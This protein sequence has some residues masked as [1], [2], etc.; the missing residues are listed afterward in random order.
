[1]L[2][3]VFRCSRSLLA[4]A[5]VFSFGYV[6]QSGAAQTAPLSPA[7]KALF[8][9]PHLSNVTHPETL[10]YTYQRTGAETL[11]D[12]I[13]VHVKEIN[14][15]GTKDL[16]FDYLTGARHVFF[17]PID[18]FR[19]NPLLMLVLERDVTMMK[20][21]LGM[22]DA[23]FRN[24]IRQAFLDGAT[25][26]DTTVPFDGAATPARTVTITPFAHEQRLERIPSLQAKTYTFTLANAVPGMIANIRI[27][28]PSDPAL[29]APEFS[30]QITFA[31]VEP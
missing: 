26:A 24:R 9:T 1:M 23:Y 16:K 15:D 2:A 18:H 31:G 27:D 25:V 11:S 4:C 3:S 29:H 7:Q 13:A 28:T 21:A 14:S 5:V 20:T 10:S 22:S 30:E 6:A 17:P 12:T 19:G 8:A